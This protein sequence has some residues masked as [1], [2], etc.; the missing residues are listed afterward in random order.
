MTASP[1][2]ANGSTRPRTPL[3]FADWRITTSAT[4]EQCT[5]EPGNDEPAVDLVAA[6]EAAT[7]RARGEAE[8]EAI[9]IAAEAAAKAEIVKAEEEA[10]KQRLANDRAERKARE[11]EAASEAR[12]AE[13]NRRREDADRARVAAAAQAEIDKQVEAEKAKVVAKAD[14]KWRG[15]AITFYTLCAAVALPVQCSAFWNPDKWWMVGAPV[16]LEIAALVVAFGT[17]AAVANKRP[18]WHFRLITWLLA[19]IAATVNLWHGLQEFDAATAIA[20][21]LASVFGPGVWD[22]HEHGR[23]R[24]RDGAPTRR[25]IKAA[26]KAAKEEAEQKLADE[27]RKRAE[28]KAADEAAAE[29]AKQLAETRAK[30]FPKVWDHALTLAADLGETAVT[31][32]IWKRAKLDVDG[33]LPGESAEVFRMRNAAEARVEAARQ[34]RPVNTL[35]KT[36]NAQRAI[37]TPRSGYRPIPPRRKRGDTP[38]Y[39]SAA[40]RAHSELLR[41]KNAAQKDP[42]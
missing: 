3:Q 28:K 39:S 42:S 29:A 13:H 22:L 10:R 23:I 27:E 37:Q 33:A 30:R 12:I 38:R 1:P 16:L 25:E 19:F 41:A 32:A 2:K 4:E 6:A 20:T 15:W 9:R 21:A 5:P 35:S 14:R 11:E 24:K 40:G 34:K 18:H 8:A 36:T 7:I 17:A 31:E 26:E